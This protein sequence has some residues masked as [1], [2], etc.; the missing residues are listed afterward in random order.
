MEIIAY[1]CGSGR[2][3]LAATND[4]QNVKMIAIFS[5]TLCIL[6]YKKYI[7]G[8]MANFRKEMISFIQSESR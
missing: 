8:G 6:Y 4:T 2:N 1:K 7:R 5:L 3:A